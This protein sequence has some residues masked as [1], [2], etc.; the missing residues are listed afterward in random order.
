MAEAFLDKVL[1]WEAEAMQRGIDIRGVNPVPDNIRGGLTTIEEKSLGAMAKAGTSPLVGVLDY[2]ERPRGPGL[3]FMATPAPATESM[4]A[5][6]AGGCQLILFATGVGN[7]SGAMVAPTIKVTGN[8]NTA[9]DFAD[10]IDFDVTDVLEK[11]APVEALGEDL[12]EFM[13][14]VASGTLTASEVLGQRE[15]AISRFAPTI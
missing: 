1:S 6:A 5:L 8:I 7:P 3:H 15:T 14:E 4:T 2:A 9:R 11:D 12:F 13:L 10:N